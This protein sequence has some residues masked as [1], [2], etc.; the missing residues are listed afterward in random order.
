MDPHLSCRCRQVF[1]A[2]E[3]C[4]GH[5]HF[6]RTAAD[7]GVHP[8]ALSSHL[9]AQQSDLGQKKSQKEQSGISEEDFLGLNH[10]RFVSSQLMKK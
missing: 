10:T 1:Q 9:V 3:H 8:S 4:Q 6:T 5:V 7:N 2:N